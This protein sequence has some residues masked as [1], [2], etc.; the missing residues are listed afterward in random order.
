MKN[1]IGDLDV[2][3][4]P[5]KLGISLPKIHNVFRWWDKDVL[6]D[7]LV[8][9][10]VLKRLDEEEKYKRFLWVGLASTVIEVANVERCHPTISFADNPFNL[11]RNN[12]KQQN[13]IN[14]N[15]VQLLSSRL[16]RMLIDL[17]NIKETVGDNIHT[18]VQIIKGDS[19]YLTR[20][21]DGDI[22]VVITSP[23][24]PNRYSYVWETRPYLYF[25][26]I[27][28]TP[29]EASDLD[30]ISIG[31]TWGRATFIL[32][33]GVIKPLNKNVEDAVG[34]IVEKIREHSN[35]LANYVQKYFNDMY[36]HF[37]ELSKVANDSARCAY[38]I[39]NSKIK[40]VEIPSDVVLAKLLECVGFNMDKIVRI[41]NRLGKRGLYEAIVYA[42][43]GC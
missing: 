10:E 30:M 32:K 15:V 29:K 26:E 14:K 40:G 20:L 34:G 13:N 6:K 8:A 7:L 31:G 19:R 18:N 5:E 33:D 23:P 37:T 38:V 1:I 9:R 21:I 27:F 25:F 28:K 43:K 39:G 24:Y 16:E 41:R 12:K 4:F 36:V 22:D 17:K 11:R 2:T 35:L 3:Q 42:T